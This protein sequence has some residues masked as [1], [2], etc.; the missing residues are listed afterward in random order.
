MTDQS[1]ME[2]QKITNFLI[3]DSTGSNLY[4]MSKISKGQEC[5]KK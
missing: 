3:M 1:K 5:S 4:E 2:S